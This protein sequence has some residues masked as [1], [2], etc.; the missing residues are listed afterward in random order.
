[1][2]IYYVVTVQMENDVTFKVYNNLEDAYARYEKLYPAF[3]CIQSDT[4]PA[5]LMAI[6]TNAKEKFAVMVSTST[7]NAS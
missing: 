5:P 6:A 2:K 3:D 7:E 1:M 4:A